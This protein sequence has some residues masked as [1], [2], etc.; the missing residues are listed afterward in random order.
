VAGAAQAVPQAL[1]N[2][3]AAGAVDSA[4]MGWCCTASQAKRWL[5]SWALVALR[6]LR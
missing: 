6:Q 3:A 1:L 2:V 5:W 4:S